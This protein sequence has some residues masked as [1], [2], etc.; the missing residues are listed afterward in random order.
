MVKPRFAVDWDA[1]CVALKPFPDMGDWLPGAPEA[2][3][4][5]CRVGTP[6]IYSCRVAE[7]EQDESTPRDPTE[8]VD[9]IRAKLREHG[10]E[11][12]EIWT[13]TYKPPAAAYIDDKGVHFDGDWNATLERVFDL[14]A[15]IKGGR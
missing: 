11:S 14:I 6:V 1:T 15:P 8:E 10:L 5:L 9:K 2:L 13:R 12:L 3:H 4:A 7:F